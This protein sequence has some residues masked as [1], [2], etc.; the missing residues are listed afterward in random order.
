MACDVGDREQLRE[1]LEG[2]PAEFPLSAVVHA[3]GVLDD[4]VI[5]SLTTG[6]CGGCVRAEGRRGVASARADRA[7]GSRGVCVVLL[8]RGDA[9]Q[10]RAGQL[11]GGQRVPGR[12]RGPP[13]CAG[14]AGGLD[15][16]GPVGAGER[17]G[18]SPRG[19]AGRA[20][21]ALRH[22][23][24]VRRARVWS[25]STRRS[26]AGRAL[27]VPAPLGRASGCAPASAGELP[28]CCAGWSRARRRAE[29]G[30]RAVAGGQARRGWRRASV[31]GWCWSSCVGRPRRCWGTPPRRRYRRSGRSRSSGSTR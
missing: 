27:V 16:V 2:V 14:A 15:G 19:R 13:S 24:A 31:S 6:A 7:S 30:R 3:A 1:L 18:G 12:A 29:P 11:R 21:R 5:D 4:G 23:P 8:G 28:R 10:P 9:R 26:R 17:D 20:D 25:C 22:A